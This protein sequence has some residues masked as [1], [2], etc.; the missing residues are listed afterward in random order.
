MGTREIKSLTGLRGVAAIGVMFF[1][2]FIF[3]HWV[4]DKISLQTAIIKSVNQMHFFVDLFFILSAFVMTLSYASYFD[5]RIQRS[6]Y[7]TYL[8]KRIARIYPLYLFNLICYLIVFGRNGLEIKQLLINLLFFN[9]FFESKYNFN[10][11]AW[12]LSVEFLAYLFF[13]LLFF[14]LA[15]LK[16]FSYLA[17]FF[18]V[19]LY[20]YSEVSGISYVLSYDDLSVHSVTQ[21]VSISGSNAIIRCLAGYLLGIGL[22]LNRNRIVIPKI[23]QIL[24]IPVGFIIS[25]LNLSI[26]FT[27]LIF[28]TLV[29]MLGQFSIIDKLFSNRIMYYLGLISYSIYLNHTL[30]SS[31]VT[32][33]FD[34]NIKPEFFLIVSILIT[35]LLSTF[36]YY[37]VEVKGG[38]LVRNY[39][40]KTTAQSYLR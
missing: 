14:L 22:A 18:S 12:S 5:K 25:L 33:F 3:V 32:K 21:N 19:F 29:L 30:V 28:S 38:K 36:T 17:L 23:L 8:L 16:H 7:K 11:V 15:K 27:V 39:F 2:Y 40:I 1:H 6:D 13:P 24:I 35:L 9:I 31:L 20:F 4:P 26:I 34:P 10:F 37:I